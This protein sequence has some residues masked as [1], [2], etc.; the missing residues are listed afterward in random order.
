M[1]SRMAAPIKR[2]KAVYKEKLAAKVKAKNRSRVKPVNIAII[3]EGELMAKALVMVTAA[4]FAH[5]QIK[6]T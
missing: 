3:Q 4:I 6:V 2:I 1:T 5:Y